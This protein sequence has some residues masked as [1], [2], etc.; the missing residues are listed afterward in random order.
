MIKRIPGY[1]HRTVDI[2]YW[3][4]IFGICQDADY[5]VAIDRSSESPALS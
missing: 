1:Y 5:W 3:V 2:D 4:A